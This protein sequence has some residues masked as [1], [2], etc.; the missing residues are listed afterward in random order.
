MLYVCSYFNALLLNLTISIYICK[1]LFLPPLFLSFSWSSLQSLMFLFH[2]CLQWKFSATVWDTSA[3]QYQGESDGWSRRNVH[4][5]SFRPRCKEEKR[6]NKEAWSVIYKN[7]GCMSERKISL[8]TSFSIPVYFFLFFF[9]SLT[10]KHA[11]LNIQNLIQTQPFASQSA[12]I[13]KSQ[14]GSSTPTSLW[15]SVPPYY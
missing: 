14:M 8:Q 4:M 13:G 12:V 1:L 7:N 5:N 15:A 2:N 11:H 9:F 3:L 10:Q 6:E